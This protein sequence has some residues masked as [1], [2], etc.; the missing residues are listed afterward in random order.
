MTMKAFAVTCEKYY[1]GKV[2]Y[3]AAETADGAVNEAQF[4]ILKIGGNAK[5]SE[6]MAMRAPEYDFVTANISRQRCIDS[7]IAKAEK[8]Q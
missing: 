7:Q 1:P 2:V 5:R 3:Y 6:I 4:S 8:I